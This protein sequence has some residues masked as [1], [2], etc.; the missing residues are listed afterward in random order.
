MVDFDSDIQTLN[1]L[2]ENNDIS[3]PD[4]ILNGLVKEHIGVLIAAP[5]MGKSHLVLSL[6]IEHCSKTKILGLSKV[7]KPSKAMLI[8]AE[9]GGEVIKSRMLEKLPH[10]PRKVSNL[11]KS[12]LIINTST[13]SIVACPEDTIET[14]T[15]VENYLSY[16]ANKIK[17]NDVSLVVVDTVSE[18]I[19]N[20]SE[21]ANDRQIK[22]AFQKLAKLSGASI[23]L[24]HHVNKL[25]IRGEAEI[26]IASM[27]GLSSVMRLSKFICT[28]I[29][30]KDD[31]KVFKYLKANYISNEEKKDFN[32]QFENNLLVN[33]SVMDLNPIESKEVVGF[34][35]RELAEINKE[36]KTIILD[37]SEPEQDKTEKKPR[38]RRRTF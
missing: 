5:D 34:T 20:A 38:T 35:D 18:I 3:K 15:N 32:L 4:Y 28:I 7:S 27:A 22:N 17:E 1:E 16:L 25:E 24:V 31:K 12:N 14:K 13:N 29:N 36:R 37:V 6:L 26:N 19:G 10:L 33:K 23:L 21:V 30:G 8:S 11:V 9:D 2:I